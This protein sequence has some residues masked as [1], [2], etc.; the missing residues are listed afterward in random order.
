[1]A[2]Q[3]SFDVG[4]SPQLLVAIVARVLPRG[5]PQPGARIVNLLA[6]NEREIRREEHVLGQVGSILPVRDAEPRERAPHRHEMGC[7]PWPE[8]SC[9]N[10]R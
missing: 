4:A 5:L 10:C 3:L 9:G 1:V 2:E 6:S 8:Q 7:E